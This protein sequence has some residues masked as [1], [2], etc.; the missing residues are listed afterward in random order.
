MFPISFTGDIKRQKYKYCR[1]KTIDGDIN[2]LGTP[3]I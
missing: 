2:T 3:H 1:N